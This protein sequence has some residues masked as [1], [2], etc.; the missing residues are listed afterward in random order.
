M[1]LEIFSSSSANEWDQFIKD[2]VNGTFLHSR[3]FLSYHKERFID[4]SVFFTDKQKIIGLL[5]AAN[6]LQEKN[7][8]CSHPGLTYGGFVHNGDLRGSNMV[9][10]INLTMEY[11]KKEGFK[12][13][14]Y[15]SIPS[16]YHKLPCQEDIYF[17]S[18]IGSLFRCDLSSCID[19]SARYEV[20]SRR[21]RSLKK[22]L[23]S[24]ITIKDGLS[25]AKS[26][27]TV[28]TENLDQ[29]YKARPVHTLEEIT[30]LGTEL[31]ENINFKSAYL[32][33]NVIAGLVLFETDTCTHAQY[34]ASNSVG[35]KFSALDLLFNVT[36]EESIQSG[37]KYFSFGTSTEDNGKF[38]NEGLYK[39][40]TEFGS[41]GQVQ[42]FFEIKL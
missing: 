21:K 29:K 40:K 12:K 3:K 36:I 25:E 6:H 19:L 28:L 30:F 35:Q 7:T 37:K 38:L 24:N 22:A 13:F 32:D 8:I 34:I 17:M 9:E 4:R 20:S 5:P 14:I 11:F 23:S 27:W 41:G 2:S 33:N 31:S 26:I 10:A 39:F 42:Q 16:I 1:N 18:N 15:K